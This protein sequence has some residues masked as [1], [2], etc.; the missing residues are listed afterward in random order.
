MTQESRLPSL[1]RPCF[2]RG[3]G[4]RERDV[5]ETTGVNPVIEAHVIISR[6]LEL[7]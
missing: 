7:Q 3:G 5:E 1:P 2:V 6:S 4:E